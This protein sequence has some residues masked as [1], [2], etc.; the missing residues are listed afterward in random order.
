M[1]LGP[2]FW[3]TPLWMR[4]SL[5][6]LLKQLPLVNNTDSLY[7][8]PCIPRHPPRPP[9]VARRLRSARTPRK[10]PASKTGRPLAGSPRQPGRQET[11]HPYCLRCRVIRTPWAVA[12]A[13]R[14][15]PVHRRAVSARAAL[16]G[17]S[18]KLRRQLLRQ[19]L[20]RQR[21]IARAQAKGTAKGH[22]HA[23]G[24]FVR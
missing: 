9:E 3:S 4:Q 13:H 10:S 22:A 18:R 11:W 2:G 7:L 23:R 21:Q 20:P 19:P 16:R 8:P 14:P 24:Q 5:Y 6:A 1:L 12:R 15:L 17:M